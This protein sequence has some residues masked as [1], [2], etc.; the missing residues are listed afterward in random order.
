MYFPKEANL[1]GALLLDKGMTPTDIFVQ[2]VRSI[3]FNQ[4]QAI[5]SLMC[6]LGLHEVS[7]NGFKR[8][9]RKQTYDT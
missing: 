7:I 2:M 5:S 1:L 3:L 4:G 9:Y 8:M 6:S